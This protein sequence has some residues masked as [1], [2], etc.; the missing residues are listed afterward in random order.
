MS[1]PLFGLQPRSSL[2]DEEKDEEKEEV[3]PPSALPFALDIGP[4]TPAVV[5]DG[6]FDE[7]CRLD[8]ARVAFPR[9]SRPSV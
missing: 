9:L 4:E 6:L 7:L 5:R 1:T 8:E 3:L 2:L